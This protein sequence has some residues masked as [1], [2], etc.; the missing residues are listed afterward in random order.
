MY[1]LVTCS[2]HKKNASGVLE[3]LL[4]DEVGTPVDLFEGHADA[5]KEWRGGSGELNRFRFVKGCLIPYQ[6]RPNMFCIAESRLHDQHF[7]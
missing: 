5:V 2:L 6:Q 4:A 3:T 7:A 1:D